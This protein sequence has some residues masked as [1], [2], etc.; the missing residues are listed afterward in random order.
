MINE[1]F[2]RDEDDIFRLSDSETHLTIR[3]VV[4]WEDIED[5]FSDGHSSHLDM[6]EAFKRECRANFNI[7]LYKRRKRPWASGEGSQ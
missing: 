2:F 5:R 3:Y 6:F 1:C 4:D 7:E